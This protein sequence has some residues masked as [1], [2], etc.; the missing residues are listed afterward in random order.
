MATA[1]PRPH[2]RQFDPSTI[3]FH[4]QEWDAAPHNRAAVDNQFTIR[5]PD[6][7]D[8]LTRDEAHRRTAIYR[9]PRSDLADRPDS[10][11]RKGSAL[12]ATLR[13]S[14]QVA[15][16]KLQTESVEYIDVA[17]PATSGYAVHGIA[18]RP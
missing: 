17:P 5:R 16:I 6:R 15:R 13:F 4:S 11:A 9:D 8:Q 10:L 2:I 1:Q 12:Y 3:R 14:G 18:V 7:V